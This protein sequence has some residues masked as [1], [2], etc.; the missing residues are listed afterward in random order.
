MP[1]RKLTKMGTIRWPGVFCVMFIRLISERKWAETDRVCWVSEI[2]A[3]GDAKPKAYEDGHY[4]MARRV[5]CYV[6]TFN[7]ERKWAE[8]DRVAGFR[9]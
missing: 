5:L 8:A 4:K 7:F 9:N 6:Y 1:N 2:S 3:L